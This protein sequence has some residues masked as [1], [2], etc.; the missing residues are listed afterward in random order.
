MKRFGNLYEKIIDKDNLREAHRLARKGKTRKKAVRYVDEHL[1]ECVDELYDILK[2][3]VYR[4][5]NYR[6]KTVYEPK[7]RM[8]YILPYYPDCIIQHAIMNV[9]KKIWDNRF[10][11][12]SYA[13]RNGK[14]QHRASQ[15]CM[16]YTKKYKYV[17]KCD[18]SK[19]FYSIPHEKLKQIIRRKIKCQETL[20][21]LDRF[22]DSTNCPIRLTS[23]MLL[24]IARDDNISYWFLHGAIK[25]LNR[26]SEKGMPIGNYLSQWLANLYL[27]ELDT[28][29]KHEL[30]IKPYLR[31]CDDFLLFA[32]DKDSLNCAKRLIREF[33][34]NKL[35]LRLSK[36]NLFPVTR[37]ID[38]LGYRH[39]PDG[40]ILV[41]KSTAKRQRKMIKA[42]WHQM[43]RNL[44]TRK[45]ALARITSIRGWM[46]WANS[47]HLQLAMHLDELEKELA[48]EK[49]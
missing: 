49:V 18:V 45:Q 32:N 47:H 3:H 39:F 23:F 38:F 36:E 48:S 42:I 12:H 14:G 16:K 10:F 6:I 27:N 19:F 1:D 24:F 13:C 40:Y 7:E 34:R 28:Y 5:S 41:R 2:D 31:Y 44:L 17:L 8:I 4:V 11:C 35:Q 33:V 21:L 37:G 29:I 25:A 22:I 15:L 43:R 9:L 46:K 20:V 26:L 30:K